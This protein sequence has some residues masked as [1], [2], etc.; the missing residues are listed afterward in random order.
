[1]VFAQFWWMHKIF[2]ACRFDRIQENA[3]REENKG[4]RIIKCVCGKEYA[5][6]KNPKAEKVHDRP[7]CSIC[8]K[9][10]YKK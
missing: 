6:K 7:Q 2:E 3:Q 1:V 5:T 9:R 4:M 8:G 10:K